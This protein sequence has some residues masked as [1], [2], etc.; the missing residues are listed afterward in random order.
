MPID[1]V[2]PLEDVGM[3]LGGPWQPPRDAALLVCAIFLP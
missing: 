1:A 2:L 3:E